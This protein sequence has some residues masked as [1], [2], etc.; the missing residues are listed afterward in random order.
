MLNQMDQAAFTTALG[1]VFE[2]T[3]AIASQVWHQRPFP[4]VRALHRHMLE[5]VESMALA[6][7]LA[8]IRAHPDL[9]ARVK[10]AAASVQEQVGAGLDQLSPEE[11]NRLLRLNQDYR[12]KFQFPFIMA[13]A[14]QTKESILNAF[15]QRLEN[16]ETTEIQQALR[17]IGQIA[18][19]RL[20]AWVIEP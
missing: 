1:D 18:W 12:T 9:G 11:Y 13:V 7:Q 19:F 2:A 10:M 8:L 3:P 4:T 17:E 16:S 15:T 14:G 6:D 20:Q 5:Q